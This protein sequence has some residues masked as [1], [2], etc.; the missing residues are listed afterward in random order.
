MSSKLKK[1]ISE[2]LRAEVITPQ[3]ASDI[4]TYYQSKK[5][6]ATSTN[7]LLV[8]FGI[9][10]SLLVGLGVILIL[11]HN[12]DAFSRPV[13]TLFS[14]VPLI[15]GQLFAALALFRKKTVVWREAS[16]TFLFFAIGASISLISQVYNV[17]GSMQDFLLAW[18]LLGTPL[19]YLLRSHAAAIL[20]LLFSTIYACNVG[21]FNDASPWYYIA[22]L[23]VIGPFYFQQIKTNATNAMTA[24]YHGLVPLSILIVMGGFITSGFTGFVLYVTLFGLFYNIGKL[25]FLNHLS[26]RKNGYVLLGSLGTII[27]LLFTTFSWVWD[28]FDSM[29]GQD[30]DVILAVSLA[31]MTITAI[32]YSH[33]RQNSKDYSWMRYAFVLFGI[34]FF[35]APVAS[36]GPKILTNLL[37]LALGIDIVRKGAQAEKFSLL[38]YGM[39][40]ITSLIACRFFD[41]DISFVLRGLLFVLMGVGFFI[42]N[43]LMYRKQQKLIP[44]DHE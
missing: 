29:R 16:A 35:L 9:L 4:S 40:I 1:D 36:E 27:T 42:A 31:I 37:V 24:L 14:F 44:N 28:D 32:V 19:I 30:Q 26:D 8:I 3:I 39:L 13:K 34:I 22:L 2:L 43:Y 7:T 41:M 38:N 33:F 23:A 17:P 20:F 15:I 6:G 18:I 10:G 25:S 21:Y 12:W 11:A 5:P